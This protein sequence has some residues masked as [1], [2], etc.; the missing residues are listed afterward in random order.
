MCNQNLYYSENIREEIDF[1]EFYAIGEARVCIV[2]EVESN[3]T[4]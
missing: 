3:C 1:G 2:G 4:A